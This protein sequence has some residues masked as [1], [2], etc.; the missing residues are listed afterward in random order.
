M[1]KGVGEFRSKGI[2]DLNRVEQASFDVTSDLGSISSCHILSFFVLSLDP[3]D[4]IE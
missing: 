1:A 3:S 4:L 2:L